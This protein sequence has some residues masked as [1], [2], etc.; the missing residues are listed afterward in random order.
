MNGGTTVSGTMVLAHLAGI[1]VFATGGLGGVHQDGQTTMDISADLTELGRT[2]VAVISSGCKSFLD[3][4]RTL[5]YLETQG[6]CVG[7]FA[8][9]RTGSVDL[10]AFWTRESGVASAKTIENEAEAAAM[11]HAQMQL[12]ISSGLLFANPIPEEYSL[13]KSEMHSVMSEALR[14]A[15]EKGVSGSA[16]TPFVLAKIRELTNGATV[17]A[18]RALVEAN[19]VRGTKVAVELAK[20]ELKDRSNSDR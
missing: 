1:K 3:I 19:V 17:T 18:N 14:Q 20:L 16:N 12:Q 9:G 11:I 7:T 2:P 15:N 8:D 6:V 4:L 13:S 5:E 10:P